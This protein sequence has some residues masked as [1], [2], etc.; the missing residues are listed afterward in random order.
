MADTD[1]ILRLLDRIEMDTWERTDDGV[2]LTDAI[3]T[4]VDNLDAEDR[5]AVL[6]ALLRLRLTER[7][8]WVLPETEGRERD[9][10]LRLVSGGSAPIQRP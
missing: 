1:K 3:E 7:I 9:R 5:E 6:V 10:L 4:T 8:G 2:P